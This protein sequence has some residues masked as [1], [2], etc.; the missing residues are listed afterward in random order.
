MYS[1]KNWVEVVRSAYQNRYPRYDQN[2]RFFVP[3]HKQNFRYLIYYA[4]RL[5]IMPIETST[6][7]LNIIYEG[8]LLINNDEKEVLKF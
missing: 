7:A 2:L 3:I 6:V 8:L 5:L 4:R 1:Q